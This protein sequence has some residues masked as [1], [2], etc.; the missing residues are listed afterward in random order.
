MDTN[1]TILSVR[2]LSTEFTLA[3]GVLRAVDNISFDLARGEVIG[4]VGESGCGK[5]ITS[6]SVLRLIRKPGKSY[7]QVYFHP[8]DRQPVDLVE[9]KPMGEEIRRIRGKYINMIFQ[10]PMNALSP[11]HTYRQPD[12]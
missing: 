12:D 8:S 10:E 2:N 6:K 3:R 9:L 5:S 11:V 4:L 7:G 1:D